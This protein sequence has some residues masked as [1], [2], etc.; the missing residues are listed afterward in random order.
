MKEND[1]IIAAPFIDI[2]KCSSLW[3]L[4]DCSYWQLDY[5]MVCIVMNTELSSFDWIDSLTLL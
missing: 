1:N 5:I 3:F 4:L 2:P